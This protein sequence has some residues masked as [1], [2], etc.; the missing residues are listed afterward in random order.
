MLKEKTKKKKGHKRDSSGH[1]ATPEEQSFL[2][3]LNTG[4]N[5]PAS[6]VGCSC[7]GD[8]STPNAVDVHVRRKKRR[9]TLYRITKR[10]NLI[11]K[12]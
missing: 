3:W 5:F 4:S 7:R 2:S 11:K 10:D 6:G 1:F 12:I 9:Y 8:Y